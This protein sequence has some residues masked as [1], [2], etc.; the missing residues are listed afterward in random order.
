MN[1]GNNPTLL[2]KFG[3]PA[4]GKV[5][6]FGAT[7]QC[8]TLIDILHDDLEVLAIYDRQII[9]PFIDAKFFNVLAEFKTFCLELNK[10]ET[11]KF[12]VAIGGNR[13]L[14]RF[15]ISNE[16]KSLGLTVMTVVSPYASVMKTAL[17]HEGVQILSNT[18]V[19]SYVEI[20]A[21]TIINN[22][23]SIDHD[24]KIGIG[25]HIAPGAT[26]AGNVEVGDM[27]FVGTNATIMPNIKVGRNATIGAGA[28]VISDVSDNDI[29]VGCPAHRIGEN[30]SE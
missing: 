11:V 28:V 15:T 12:I 8:K 29:V 17:V 10:S 2:G 6:I 1:Y 5:V 9:E 19:G 24:C 21:F 20:G 13:G 22:S 23:S 30:K 16:L 3:D 18:Y 7:G 27:T 4:M 25:C 14:E 26:L